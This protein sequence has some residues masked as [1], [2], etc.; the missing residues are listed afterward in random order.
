M[1]GN[2]LTRGLVMILGYA[3]PAYEC[4]KTVEKN[5]PEI[6]QLRFWCQYWI[7][8]ALLTVFER[9]GDTF[10][11]WVPMYSEAKLAF[12]IYLWYPRTKGTTYVYESFFRPYVVKHETEID[13]NLMEL[14]TRAGDMAFMYFQ[15]VAIYGQT[16]IFEILQ[17]VAAQSNPRPRASQVPIVSPELC[18]SSHFLRMSF[19][20][21]LFTHACSLQQ[22]PAARPHQPPAAAAAL[23]QPPAKP[24][25]PQPQ[26]EEPPSPTSS[27]SSTQ[28]EKEAEEELNSSKGPSASPAAPAQ[29]S[30]PLKKSVSTPPASAH[31][32]SPLKKSVSL[33]AAATLPPPAALPAP[34]SSSQST[35]NQSEAIQKTEPVPASPRVGKTVPRSPRAPQETVMEETIRVTRG[36]LR[37]ARSTTAK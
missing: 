8:V 33:P 23:R 2:L 15:K 28:P 4:F 11:S 35:T 3:Y 31:A 34:E 10:V 14:R 19:L 18:A 32:L 9:V 12:I 7:L 30:T 16:R 22:Q 21:L 26:N 1:I 17:F 25:A 37:K 20:Q 13:R 24:Q 5:K 29:A 6:D 27:T 36:R